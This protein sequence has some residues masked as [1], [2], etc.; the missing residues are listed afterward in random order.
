MN[1]PSGYIHCAMLGGK[2]CY[3]DTGVIA[4]SSLSITSL[5]FGR[6][7]SGSNAVWFFGARNTNSTTSAGQFNFLHGGGG[8]TAYLGYG[9]T[10]AS[11]S[12]YGS[13]GSYYQSLM[14]SGNLFEIGTR[15]VTA[16]AST[17]TGTRTIYLLALNNAGTETYGAGANNCDVMLCE[18][19]I[20]DSGTEIHH[21]IPVYDEANSRFGLY[22]FVDETFLAN[23]GTGTFT[24]EYLLEIQSSVG[25]EGFVQT[26][27]VG[28]IKKQ[29]IPKIYTVNPVRLKA[30][31]QKG[32]AFKNWTDGNGNVLS[33]EPYFEYTETSA[34]VITQD[35]VITANFVK[36]ADIDGIGVGYQLLG[37]Q[38]GVGQIG[39][40]SPNG[41][42]SDIYASVLS[43]EIMTDIYERT[44]STIIVKEVPGLFQTGIP[45]FLFSPTGKMMWCGVIDAIEGNTLTC[46]EAQSMYD[47]E[48][49][50]GSTSADL[51]DYTVPRGIYSYIATRYLEGYC[52]TNHIGTVNYAELKRVQ[53]MAGIYSGFAMD[54]NIIVFGDIQYPFPTITGSETNNVE[55][56]FFEMTKQYG[57][58]FEPS[59]YN[60]FNSSYPSKGIKHL[61]G[62]RFIY[63]SRYGT[64]TIG[65]NS[66]SISNVDVSKEEQEANCLTIYNSAG[67]TLRGVYAIKTDGSIKDITSYG[68][69]TSD[70]FAYTNCLN[71]VVQS[72]DSIK[73]LVKENLG[74]G[75][76]NHKITFDVDL[77]R[78]VY[79][80]DDFVL[81]KKVFFYDG[82]ALYVSMITAI[83]YSG[84]NVDVQFMKVTLGNVRTNLT[85][86]LNMGR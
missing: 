50:F 69:L 37:L 73:I 14:N 13:Y 71:K 78:E 47:N 18:F 60:H 40:T 3:F 64:M 21:Y 32:Y 15:E 66:E 62:I 38:Y 25:G 5:I 43:Y 11:L 72:D 86:K 44:N 28:F 51:K 61:L 9:S 17:F 74:N 2:N 41:N 39:S 34:Y 20:S 52:D 29:Y 58:I 84:D 30:I 7:P 77:T 76:L 24:Q 6:V 49:V 23:Q 46:R 83:E 36:K 82:S 27:S 10:R 42:L 53:T 35:T 22:D 19:A 80:F 81:G 65:T 75:T 55:D 59:L 67:S 16:T 68:S 54:W 26:D 45:V 8:I 33:T 1:L 12:N 63:P 31:P 4:S 79:T 56:F 48:M 57:V 70:L 85:S